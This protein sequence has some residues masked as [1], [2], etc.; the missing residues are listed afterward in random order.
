MSR[1]PYPGTRLHSLRIPDELW[2][3]ALAI[4]RARQESV[5]EVV[6]RA[7]EAY[8]A[9]HRRQVPWQDEKERADPAP[10]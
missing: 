8:V 1:P 5:T 2:A 10:G 6:V 4:T 9:R 7:L 3:D